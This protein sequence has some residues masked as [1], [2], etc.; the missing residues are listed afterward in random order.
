MVIGVINQ[1]NAI[2][3]GPHI[4]GMTIQM[5]RPAKPRMVVTHKLLNPCVV[6]LTLVIWSRHPFIDLTGSNNT[7][8][9]GMRM[10][11]NCIEQQ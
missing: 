11:Q 7:D 3:W 9:S 2:V 8:L 5:S 10:A 1:L 6:K 4:V